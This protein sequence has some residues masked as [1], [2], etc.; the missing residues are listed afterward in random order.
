VVVNVTEDSAEPG[1]VNFP[2]L[3]RG[4]SAAGRAELKRPAVDLLVDV[5]L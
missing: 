4:G 2:A 1:L 5:V 3:A